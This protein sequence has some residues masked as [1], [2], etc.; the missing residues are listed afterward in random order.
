V[1]NLNIKQK[2]G[3]RLFKISE[4][5]F[6]EEYFKFGFRQQLFRIIDYDGLADPANVNIKY[7]EEFALLP[8]IKEAE[9][10]EL[11][12]LTSVPH[13]ISSSRNMRKIVTIGIKDEKIQDFRLICNGEF[14]ENS[15]YLI[16]SHEILNTKAMNKEKKML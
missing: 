13:V 5:I 7:Q 8:I 16:A 3:K 12:D 11:S 10:A 15:K 4:Y 2:D 14:E 6:I 1:D 9:F